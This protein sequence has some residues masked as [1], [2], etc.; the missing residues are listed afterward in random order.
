MTPNT[1]SRY[2]GINIFTEKDND[3]FCGRVQDAQKLFNRLMLNN[4]LVL[5][6]E[7]GTGKSSLV[8]AGLMHL[9][10]KYNNSL[11]ARDKPRYLPVTIRF[12][13]IRKITKTEEGGAEIEKELL[14]GHTLKAISVL[15]EYK[16]KE[17]PYIGSKDNNLWYTAKLFER[18]KYTLLL[19]FDQFEELQSYTHKEVEAFTRQLSDL[20]VSTMPDHIYQEYDE[21]T[22]AVGSKKEMTKEERKVYNQDIKF[23]EQPLKVHIL[24]VVREDKLGTISLLSDYFPDILKNDFFL[25]PLD[26]SGAQRAIEEPAGKDGEFISEKFAFEPPAVEHILQ[27]LVDTSTGLY[28]P[29]QLQIVCSSIEKKIAV[30]K[31]L[32]T[33]NDIPAVGDIISDF[34]KDIWESI[35]VNYALNDEEY[36]SRRRTIIEE[37]VVGGRRN[38]VLEDRLVR[39]GNKL[40]ENIMGSLVAEGLLRKIPS[41]SAVFY[42][43]CHDRL[44]KPLAIDLQSLKA[45][46]SVQQETREQK[47]R[48][49][50]RWQWFLLAASILLSITAGVAF[51]FYFQAKKAEGNAEQEKYQLISTSLKR[52]GNPTLGYVIGRNFLEKKPESKKMAEYLRIFDTSTYVYLTGIYPSFSRVMSADIEEENRLSITEEKYLSTW[53]IQKEGMV[54]RVK[55]RDEAPVRRIRTL[56]GQLDF[57]DM[58]DSILIKNEKGNTLAKILTNY[59]MNPENIAIS[60]DNHYLLVENE[61]LNRAN[62]K[63][64]AI[65]PP[66]GTEDTQKKF[67]EFERT[68]TAFLSNNRVAV[69]YENGKIRIYEIDSGKR[70]RVNMIGTLDTMNDSLD[71]SKNL[72]DNRRIGLLVFDT[73]LN[74]LLAANSQNGIDIY[75][76]GRFDPAGPATDG[77]NHKYHLAELKGHSGLVKCITFSPDKKQLLSGASDY[78]AILWDL[79]NKKQITVLKTQRTSAIKQVRFSSKDSALITVS[80]E[81]IVR[82]WKRS[83]PETLYKKQQLYRFSPFNYA[84]WGL[85]ENEYGL[86]M[87][88]TGTKWFYNATLNYLLNIPSIREYPDEESY[89]NTLKATVSEI[90]DMYHRL[91]KRTDFHKVISDA[92]KILLDKYYYKLLFDEPD[93]VQGNYPKNNI[94][95]LILMGKKE[96]A[97][98]NLSLLDTTSRDFASITN[99]LLNSYYTT[100]YR[101]ID[102]SRDTAEGIMIISFYRDSILG[103]LTVRYGANSTLDRLKRS[104][105]V[106]FLKYYL[107]TGKLGDAIKKANELSHVVTRLVDNNIYLVAVYLAAG[108][109]DEA[110]QLYKRILNSTGYVRVNSISFLQSLLTKLLRRNI[111]MPDIVRFNEEFDLKHSGY[112]QLSP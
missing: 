87:D 109:Y 66:Y 49:R 53:D 82:V 78:T 105:N 8:Q 41:G 11:P 57:F 102:N 69:G 86:P 62:F 2:P 110:A 77:D 37:L 26:Q 74:Y 73:T 42:Q 72:S 103:P 44:R 59:L 106:S 31:R 64:I 28:D 47:A 107:Y 48:V 75:Y 43:L 54:G 76:I 20:F 84:V 93:L 97:E 25:L 17:L 30:K 21:K 46:E 45:K 98:W 94:D 60:P 40:D 3:I 12:D 34:Y 27:N 88:T 38:L 85:K 65:L 92:N 39:E 67:R 68:S 90:K 89:N 50:R 36:D 32:I 99:R 24:F 33:I 16:A 15:N 111:A 13:S 101:Y 91:M 108:K 51:Y 100:T 71:A 52:A 79:E 9:L 81:D 70:R 80:D 96:N 95:K 18:N 7:S 19:V 61:I 104:V 4:T 112:K 14:L 6:G 23:L 35:K 56:D 1:R 10:E 55:I 29:I 58:G 5:H 63:N 22:T 83:R